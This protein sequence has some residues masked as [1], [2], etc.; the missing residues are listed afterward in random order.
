MKKYLIITMI[1]FAVASAGCTRDDVS[2]PGDETPGYTGGYPL[3][4]DEYVK[5]G[6]LQIKLTPDAVERFN[7]VATRG[8]ISTGVASIDLLVEQLGVTE[9]T[10]TFRHGG[11]HE[12]RMRA[13]GLHLWYNVYF[14]ADEERAMTRAFTDFSNLEDLAVV[15]P[16]LRI[17]R[18]E[19]EITPV[20]KQQMAEMMAGTRA[21]AGYGNPTDDP[22]LHHQWHYHNEGTLYRSKPGADINLFEAWKLETGKPQ[23]IVAVINGGIDTDHPDLKQNLWVNEAELYGTEGVDD[24]DNGF[25]DDVYGYNFVL[26]E[27]T[28]TLHAHGTHVA[29][30]VAAVNNNGIGV[31]GVAGGNGS[32]D[33]G[34]R[35]MSCQ[36]FNIDASGKETVVKDEERGNA[37]T[38]AANNGAVIAQNSWEYAWTGIERDLTES[39][40]AAI[41][42]FVDYA[43]RDEHGNQ[44]GPLDG[45]IVI[46][47]TGNSNVN[48]KVLP[49][50]YEKVFS[51]ASHGAAYER[52]YYSNYGDWVHVAAPGG[53][54]EY[55]DGTQVFSTYPMGVYGFMEGTSMACP[56]VSGIAALVVS[57]FGVN[58]DGSVNPGFTNEMLWDRLLAGTNRT[59]LWHNP[60]QYPMGVGYIDAHKALALPGEFAPDRISDLNIEWTFE[61][62]VVTWRVTADAD[63]PDGKTDH[64]MYVVSEDDLYGVDFKNLPA[65]LT[66]TT[67]TTAGRN[68]GDV[69][70]VE[71]TNL[72][73]A[74]TYYVS[75]AGGDLDGNISASVTMTGSLTVNRGPVAEDAPRTV[76]LRKHE[77]KSYDVTVYDPEGY[78]W[79]YTFSPGSTGAAA[80]RQGDVITLRFDAG[81]LATG[82]YTAVLV[83]SDE[84][85]V[86]TE[87]TIPYTVVAYA[88]ALLREFESVLFQG[89]GDSRQYV[90]A[91]YFYDQDGDAI[92]YSAESSDTGIV[93]ATIGTGDILTVTSTGLGTATVKVTAKD[94][95]GQSEASFTVSTRDSSQ[96]VDLY[97]VPVKKDGV[98]NIRMG[99][100]V[101]GAVDITIYSASGARV[102]TGQLQMEAGAAQAID[103]SSLATGNYRIVIKHKNLE[104]TRNITKL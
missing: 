5:P 94:V 51:V 63:A 43:G 97:P 79:S 78:P 58:P 30:T 27:G 69:I 74:K 12:A 102:Y 81:G 1:A 39:D 17:K 59:I 41:D 7:P 37:F 45:G 34:I 23:V 3:E 35:L 40:R 83:L 56:H 57:R 28:I 71:L 87:V 61:K 67:V 88:P 73:E 96:E 90:L 66:P 26:D 29:G 14:D 86:E 18:I 46:F 24:D 31:A 13:A 91:D 68:V 6:V 15:E 54:G 9:I 48:A 33:S 70:T 64:Y 50:S 101:N 75:V 93:T 36:I 103:I 22:F 72:E 11:K 100:D 85:G 84:Q 95:D 38:Y 76:N 53:T 55:A 98:L 62:A 65:G 2:L 44:T 89:T 20:T 32:P 8:G 104:I 19:S 10:R 92:T 4:N 82:T 25:I 47:A 99:T 52:A 60:V 16:V 49:A 42:Y 21:V 77:V 80:T